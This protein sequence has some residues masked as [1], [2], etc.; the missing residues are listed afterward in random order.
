MASRSNGYRPDRDGS[1]KTPYQKQRARILN[2]ETICAICGM[3]VDKSLKFPHPMSPTIDH[4]VPVSLGGHPS[5]PDNLQ[6]A[7]LKCNQVKSSRL[8]IES[9]KDLIAENKQIGNRILPQS[10]NWKKYGV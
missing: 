4:I 2:T 3:P 6:L 9:N 5:D 10:M 1:F 8:T 7:H